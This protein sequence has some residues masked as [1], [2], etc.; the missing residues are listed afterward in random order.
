M[1]A[2]N[3]GSVDVANL[4]LTTANGLDIAVF[5][6]GNT[7]SFVFPL[8][9]TASFYEVVKLLLTTTDSI[10]YVDA[11]DR[12]LTMKITLT[13]FN[14]SNPPVHYLK[15]LCLNTRSGFS[16][17]QEAEAPS[18]LLYLKNADESSFVD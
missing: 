5:M 11:R 2:Y 1:H 10:K 14:S 3:C 15:A 13:L 8:I 7:A 4:L 6:S 12:T 16:L 18:F 9:N 17:S